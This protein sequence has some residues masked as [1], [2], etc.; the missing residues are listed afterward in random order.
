MGSKG[1]GRGAHRGIACAA[2][3][4]LAWGSAAAQTPESLTLD[5]AVRIALA[6]NFDVQVS[7]SELAKSEG[8]ERTA[9]GA[10]GPNVALNATY[11]RNEFEG[12]SGQGGGFFRNESKEFGVSL[13]QSV[14]LSGASRA[15]L[16]AA[17][18][19]VAAAEAGLDATVA[20][21][22]DEARRAY[23]DVL[24][25]KRLVEVSEEARDAAAKR[26][27]DAQKR[28]AEGV[29]SRFDVLRFETD[30]RRS[31]EAV[32]RD[33]GRY[34]ISRQQLNNLLARPVETSFVPEDVSDLPPPAAPDD[35]LVGQA[36]QSR[37]EVRQAQAVARSLAAVVETEKRGLR[38][39]LGIS[40][41]YTRALDPG[42]GSPDATTTGA[43]QLQWPLFDSGVTRGRVASADEDRR[44]AEFR[45]EQVLL[46]VAL[47]VRSAATRYRVATEAYR[48]ATAA[49][50]LA[51]EALRLAEV[52]YQNQVGTLLDVVTAQAELTAAKASATNARY[53]A[54]QAYS[55]LLR[56]LGEGAEAAP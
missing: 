22:A 38:P 46:A 11:V 8:T 41:S 16:R 26:L 47:D 29:V 31:E 9:R 24:L 10:F 14:D 48:T 18:E 35:A 2:A 51:A 55:S 34:E 44:Q 37:P 19:N 3:V 1:Q 45:L 54:W 32:I 4:V 39:S 17:R 50:T 56:A 15:A 40:A 21:V 33:G 28:A 5:D 49:Q 43:I 23:F 27:S 6:Q 53:E 13:G 42:I 20:R 25:A 36:V 52:S 7:R 30:L 12:L